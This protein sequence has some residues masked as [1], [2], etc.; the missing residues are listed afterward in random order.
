L[1]QG[2]KENLTEV[3]A[4]AANGIATSFQG[5]TVEDLMDPETW[6]GMG[7]WLSYLMRIQLEEWWQKLTG[8]VGKV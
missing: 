3:T 8:G 2:I 6:K 7:C 4:A 1:V 5:A